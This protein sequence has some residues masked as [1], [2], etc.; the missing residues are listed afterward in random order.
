VSKRRPRK[1]FQ[2]AICARVLRPLRLLR[3]KIKKGRSLRLHPLNQIT[4]GVR[5]LGDI[6]YWYWRT[7]C[8]S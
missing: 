3:G 4:G 1:I 5:R 6:F 7:V 8:F 2:W